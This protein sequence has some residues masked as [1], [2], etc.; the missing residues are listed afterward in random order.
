MKQTW[1]RGSDYGGGQSATVA[2]SAPQPA[3]S[4]YVEQ[5]LASTHT[6]PRLSPTGRVKQQVYVCA[7]SARSPRR[8]HVPSVR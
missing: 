6:Q 3:S 4:M 7:Q 8:S 5:S 1:L 2:H